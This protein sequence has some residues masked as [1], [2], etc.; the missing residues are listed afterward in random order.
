MLFSIVD[1][2]MNP[3]VTFEDAREAWKHFVGLENK[4][5][6]HILVR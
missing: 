1:E 3:V 4:D 6:F 2:K 5:S